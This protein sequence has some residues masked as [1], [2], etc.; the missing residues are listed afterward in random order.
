VLVVDAERP[1]DVGLAAV[2]VGLGVRELGA[3]RRPENLV[4]HH[5]PL[6]LG[7]RGAARVGVV[8]R[9]GSAVDGRDVER[10]ARL[11]AAARLGGAAVAAALAAVVVGRD[12]ADALLARLELADEDLVAF[13]LLVEVV[14][15]AADRVGERLAGELVVDLGEA[16]ADRLLAVAELLEAHVVPAGDARVRL[17][18]GEVVVGQ[19]RHV[20]SSGFRP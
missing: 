14:P 9:V 18:P 1:L 6:A 19:S 20:F 15:L 10:R 13:A 11:A 12:R 2:L 16:S 17:A 5:A 4:V 8:P 7:R 3:F